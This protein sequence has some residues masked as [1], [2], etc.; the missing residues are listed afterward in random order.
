MRGLDETDKEILRLLLEDGRRPYSDI[1]STVDLSAP[2]VSDRIDRLQEV[3]LLRRFT[4]DVDRSL[5][6]EGTAVLVTIQGVPGSGKRLHEEL[7]SNPAVEY[8]FR[9]ADETLVCTAV[10]PSDDIEAL[11]SDDFP[12][13]H[14]RRYNVQLLQESSW[15][16]RFDDVELAP[17]CVECGN[18]VSAEGERERFDGELY[19]FCCS[20]CLASFRTQYNRLSEQS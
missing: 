14:V 9:T 18:T 5:L 4:V 7:L 1:A 2:A 20:S 16:P 15:S 12:I 3:G 19:H 11:F 17:E 6:R 13:E 10:L 8:A